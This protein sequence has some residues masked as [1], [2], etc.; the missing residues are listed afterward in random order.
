MKSFNSFHLE[1]STYPV[2]EY[3]Q[4][5]AFCA[6]YGEVNPIVNEESRLILFEVILV[7]TYSHTNFEK[8]SEL[9]IV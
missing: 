2:H 8:R 4:N 3:I 7:S 5:Q 9:E 6:S 1:N